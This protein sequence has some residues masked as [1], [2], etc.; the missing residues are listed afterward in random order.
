[1]NSSY[2]I[3]GEQELAAL[4]SKRDRFAQRELYT[5]YAARVNALCR[6]Y[7][8]DTADAEDLTLEVMAKVLNSI[9]RYEYKGAG[10]L[11]AWICKLAANMAVDKLRRKGRLRFL[12]LDDVE[13]RITAQSDIALPNVSMDALRLMIDKIPDTQRV[14]LNMFCLEGYSHKEIAEILGIT[15]KASSSLLSKAKKMLET[16]IVDY[17]KT[18]ND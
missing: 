8:S 16:K 4:C 18:R 5:R 3:L 6:R 2:E 15:E 17:I 14:I 7:M 13:G 11:Q 12:R 10:S 9:G 1:M